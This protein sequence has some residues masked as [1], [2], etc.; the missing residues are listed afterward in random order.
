MFLGWTVKVANELGIFHTVFIVGAGYSMAIYLPMV[1][2]L[3]GFSGN[4][5]S[6]FA[7]APM[8]FS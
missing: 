4:A 7:Y 6:H 5:N 1:P 3:G 8:Q 2:I